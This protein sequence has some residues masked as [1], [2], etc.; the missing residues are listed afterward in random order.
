MR[1]HSKIPRVFSSILFYLRQDRRASH[2][3]RARYERLNRTADSSSPQKTHAPRNDTVAPR[4]L[5][6]QISGLIVSRAVLCVTLAWLSG[7][8]LYKPANP[9]TLVFLI[10]SSPANLDPRIG[11]DAQSERLDGLMY[12]SLIGHDEKMNP[13]PDLA[14]SWENPDPLTYVF[15][16]RHGVHFQDGQPF[17][18]ADVK[19]T[20]DSILSGAIKTPKRGAYHFVASVSAPDHYTVVFHMKQPDP[21][22]LWN[23]MR[24]SIG[25]VPRGATPQIARHPDGTG[26]FR[27]V[28]MEP[29]EEI[30]LAPNPD[31]FGVRPEVSRVQCRIVPDATVR[32]LE[33]R[34][35]SADI[36][37]NNLD[38]DT[39]V[40]LSHFHGIDVDD[41]PG[42]E[43]TYV[44][45]NFLDPILAHREVRQALAYATD[46]P[47]IIRYLLRG[48]ARPASS[49]LPPNHWAYDPNVRQYG[50]DP[51]KAEELLDAAG[52]KR[53]PDGVRF[54]LTL[55][56][57]TDEST[58]LYASA[59]QEQW[60]QVGIALE[61]RPLE[62]ATFYS[63]IVR[64]SFQLYTARWVGGNNDPQMFEYVFSSRRFPP[65]GANRGHY[66]NP[67]LDALLD[68]SDTET[69]RD[70]RKAIFWQVQQI[71]ADDEPYINLW[72]QDSVAVFR[73]RV[74]NLRLT[75]S[76][77]YDFLQ[78]AR[79]RE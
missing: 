46:R 73:D 41:Q 38:P 56:T 37:P 59:L 4:R 76:G 7:C 32:A 54:H 49:L 31:Y 15:H 21:S 20:F 66:S 79:L 72:Y 43:V 60:K 71:V 27:F 2:P 74:T 44:A 55:K 39:V 24:P 6:P 16:L 14:E 50:Y 13:T 45:F 77:D 23:L 75:P 8:A 42:T 25:I 30:I 70:K 33:L 53:R 63:D 68:Q 3:V 29:D 51:Q 36:A 1:R 10:E 9:G 19:F 18:S 61:L 67:Q 47:M 62:F 57:S 78:F 69:D 17:S 52:F 48:Q 34:K 5:F 22:L 28:S 65:N 64:G 40:A 12:S 58:R 35:G 11:T 26:P